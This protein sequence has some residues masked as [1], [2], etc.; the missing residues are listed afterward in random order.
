[1]SFA[2]NFFVKTNCKIQFH[3][4]KKG[5]IIIGL[6]TQF[7]NCIE[8]LQFTVFICQECKWTICMNYR[9][10]I[11]H[12]CN[13]IHL[14]FYQNNSFS[15]TMQPHYNCSHDVMLRSLIVIHLTVELWIFLDTIFF[16]TKYWFPSS[17]MIVNDGLKL[18]YVA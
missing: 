12:I 16:W 17:I 13:A 10:I 1:M 8:H 11:H 4:E 3:Y 18:W 9:V 5:C 15:N 2:T 7:L 14:Q 6:A